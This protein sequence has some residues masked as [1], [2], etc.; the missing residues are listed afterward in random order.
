MTRAQEY[1]KAHSQLETVTKE[2]DDELHRLLKDEKEAEKSLKEELKE[3]EQLINL[4]NKGLQ[5][6]E[7]LEEVEEKVDKYE[8]AHDEG[9]DADAI[10]NVF[11]TELREVYEDIEQLEDIASDLQGRL[12]KFKEDAD[13]VE[14][15]LADFNQIETKVEDSLEKARE[16]RNRLKQID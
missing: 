4:T 3:D 8:R 9:L 2:L 10:E 15:E 16:L 5:I 12:K 14:Q 13:G 7:S 11:G 1:E 6:L